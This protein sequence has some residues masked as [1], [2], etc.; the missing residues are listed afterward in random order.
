MEVVSNQ[1]K[2]YLFLDSYTLRLCVC[3]EYICEQ[4]R[5]L[6]RFIWPRCS[7]PL[8]RLKT[9]LRSTMP[10]RRLNH[11]TKCHTQR[12]RLKL[13]KSE[14]FVVVNEYRRKVPVF[15]YFKMQVLLAWFY[16]VIAVCCCS[17]SLAELLFSTCAN[18]LFLWLTEVSFHCQSA[19]ICRLILNV[20]ITYRQVRNFYL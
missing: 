2:W 8:L 9:W 11:V 14:K 19:L 1:S 16:M 10:Q 20:D 7:G 12:E 18:K 15:R 4:S 5:V 6:L 17:W 3:A 13:L